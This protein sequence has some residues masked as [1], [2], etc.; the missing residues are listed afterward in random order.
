MTFINTESVDQTTIRKTINPNPSDRLASFLKYFIVIFCFIA[1][2]YAFIKWGI[3]EKVRV[4]GNSMLPTLVDQQEINI[5]KFAVKL[6]N[7]K[8]GQIIVLNDRGKL[9]IKRVIALSGET[10][11][12]KNKQVWIYNSLKP[13]GIKLEEN[14]LG[15]DANQNT[16]P[17]CKIPDCREEYEKVVVGKSELYVLG[18]NRVDSKDSRNY[19]PINKSVVYGILSETD[20]NKR[21]KFQ[22]P[23]YNLQKN[24]P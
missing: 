19:G 14:Y 10:I 7:Y 5:E 22:L 2:G 20:I 12:F 15:K 13:E 9:L 4:E 23:N 21:I 17:T 1:L 18:D 8:R 24:S 6:G 16:Y 11:E 3:T